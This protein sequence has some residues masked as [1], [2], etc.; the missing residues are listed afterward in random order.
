MKTFEAVKTYKTRSICD[1]NCIISVNVIS[2]TAKTIKAETNFGVKS[3]RPFVYGGV[4]HIKPWGTYS[5][6]P[7]LSSEDLA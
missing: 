3:F 6:C 7:V 5:M 4:E 2:R 1:N